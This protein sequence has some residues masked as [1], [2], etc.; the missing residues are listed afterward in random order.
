MM[1]DTDSSDAGESVKIDEATVAT[2]HPVHFAAVHRE[3]IHNYVFI[4][5][6]PFPLKTYLSPHPNNP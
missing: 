5:L 3:A 2:P 1:D 4:F 6:P